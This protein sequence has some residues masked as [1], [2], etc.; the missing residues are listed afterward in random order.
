MSQRIGGVKATSDDEIMCMAGAG[1]IL[2]GLDQTSTGGG[3]AG[4]FEGFSV[5]EGFANNIGGT[6][7]AALTMLLSEDKVRLQ[8][9]GYITLDLKASAVAPAIYDTYAASA[10]SYGLKLAGTAMTTVNVYKG[11]VGIGVEPDDTTTSLT[12]LNVNYIS[13]QSGD[14]NVTIGSGVT[15]SGHATNAIATVN[16]NGGVVTS[17]GADIATVTIGNG[18]LVLSDDAAISTAVTMNNGRIFHDSSGTVTLATLNGGTY[19]ATRTA[20]AKTISTLKINSGTFRR[21]PG[22]TTVTM[23]SNPDTPTELTVSKI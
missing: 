10:G 23:F 8:G 5:E 20:N 21:D 12:N 6:D 22:D 13:S 16:M 17:K 19:D 15:I 18:T 1:A 14:S 3:T 11:V 7:D 9:T 4:G 2:Y